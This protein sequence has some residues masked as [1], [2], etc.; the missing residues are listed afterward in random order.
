MTRS[1]RIGIATCF[2][3]ATMLSIP[4]VAGAADIAC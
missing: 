3:V 4:R 2:A 1:K